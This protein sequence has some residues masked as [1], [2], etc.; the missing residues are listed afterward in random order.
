[1][2]TENVNPVSAKMVHELK[3]P[4]LDNELKKV[5]NNLLME[6]Y[7]PYRQNVLIDIGDLTKNTNADFMQEAL[8]I[9]ELYSQ[10]GWRVDI[11]TSRDPK[12]YNKQYTKS[13]LFSKVNQ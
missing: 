13:V 11:N 4:K 7:C 5:I 2:G 12:N 10:F 3:R 6:R 1:M 8:L 9:Q